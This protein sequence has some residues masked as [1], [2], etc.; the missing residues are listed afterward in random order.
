MVSMI[1]PN[2]AALRNLRRSSPKAPISSK[3]GQYPRGT[4]AKMG[5]LNMEQAKTKMMEMKNK[6]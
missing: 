2:P 4:C 3:I 1:R 5:G 6:S